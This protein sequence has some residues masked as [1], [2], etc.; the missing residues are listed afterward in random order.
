MKQH[1]KAARSYRMELPNV[2]F[3]NEHFETLLFRDL[4]PTDPFGIGFVA[5]TESGSLVVPTTDPG[6]AV[7]AVRYDEKILP[8]AV[9]KAE[10]AKTI[11]DIYE[12]E[13]RRV[14]RKEACDIRETVLP[15][16]LAKSH[17]KTTVIRCFYNYR[18][19]LLIVP[20]A[21]KKYADAVTSL[22]VKAIES[23]KATTIYVAGANGSLTSRLSNELFDIGDLGFETFDLSGKCVLKDAEG[24]KVAIDLFSLN[25]A[26]QAVQEAMGRGATVEEIGLEFATGVTFRLTKDFVLKGIKWSDEA[27]PKDDQDD[28]V[29][30]DY[31]TR[32]DM[33]AEVFVITRIVDDLCKMLGYKEPGAEDSGDLF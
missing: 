15:S 19:K 5:P 28:D 2:A 16:L 1:I 29:D 24:G 20:T 3:L 31:S 9:I 10:V 27:M 7:F 23:I 32:N 22:M 11:A 17:T 8:A 25:E 30:A 33:A 12:R 18:A 13:G 4:A 21:S 26:A 14:G 6:I